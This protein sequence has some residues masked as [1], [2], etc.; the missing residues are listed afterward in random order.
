VNT[1]VEI[2][3]QTLFHHGPIKIL[4]GPLPLRALFNYHLASCKLDSLTVSTASNSPLGVTRSPPSAPRHVQ[5]VTATS[6]T[7]CQ[8][9]HHLDGLS[10]PQQSRQQFTLAHRKPPQLPKP[11]PKQPPPLQPQPASLSQPAPTSAPNHQTPAKAIHP[12]PQLAVFLYPA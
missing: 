8:R 11:P 5:A 6:R 7:A 3:V 4:A 2:G 10:Q 12:T 9:A 1:N